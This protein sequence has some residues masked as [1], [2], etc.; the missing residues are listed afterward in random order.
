MIIAWWL[1]TL[2]TKFLFVDS[3]IYSSDKFL[4][5][6]DKEPYFISQF[7]FW[8]EGEVQF[9]VGNFGFLD[10]K[11]DSLSQASQIKLIVLD[12]ETW[13]GF[14]NYVI[15]S[16]GSYCSSIS[17]LP[18]GNYFSFATLNPIKA[19]EP[20]DTQNP[21]FKYVVRKEGIYDVLLMNCSPVSVRFSF[22]TA[23]INMQNGN[24]NHL[25]S[26][27]IPLPII[28]TVFALGIWPLMVAF[29]TF[30][31]YK[32]RKASLFLYSILASQAVISITHSLFSIFFFNYISKTGEISTAMQVLRALL[33]FL[34]STI[35]FI[36][37]MLISKGWGVL[38]ISL[39]SQEKRIIFA[40]A[41]FTSSACTFYILL[42]GS[43]L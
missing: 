40:L 11:N 24:I 4:L 13:S 23:L 16:Q 33:I 39:T 41:T 9:S 35:Y 15:G 43:S 12:D 5:F 21:T 28:Y 22:K 2:A 42:G 27:D 38:R 37:R 32:Y 3:M 8:S 6:P 10:S 29:W 20:L 31:W 17:F 7:S 19:L 26:G 34:T 1:M 36:F 30:N 18:A 14:T 25:D